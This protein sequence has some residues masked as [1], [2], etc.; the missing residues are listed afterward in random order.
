[1]SELA[2]LRAGQDV[3]ADVCRRILKDACNEGLGRG[4]FAPN[5]TYSEISRR[6]ESG[7][8]EEIKNLMLAYDEERREERKRAWLARSTA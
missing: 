3:V 7:E 5:L 6:K 8:L 1:L 4:M 2:K